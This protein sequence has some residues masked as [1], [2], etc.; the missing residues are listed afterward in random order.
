MKNPS[1]IAILFFSRSA[2]SE[3]VHKKWTNDPAVDLKIA[4]HL[5]RHARKQLKAAPFPIFRVN[6]SMQIGSSFG[7]KLANAFELIFQKGFENVIAVGN[8]CPDSSVNWKLISDQLKQKKSI[9]GPDKR[10]GV[11]LIGISAKMDFRSIFSKV[12]WNSKLV[13]RQLSDHLQ[14]VYVLEKKRDIN[15]F[16]DIQSNWTLR[17]LLASLAQKGRPVLFE[18]D[19]ISKYTIPRQLLRAPPAA[20]NSI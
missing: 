10:G 19:L 7:E 1:Q 16:H 13:F 6:D 2:E 17:S 3:A 15:N 14:N 12:R 20:H 18:S 4:R 9:L 5:I 11:Y 8:D